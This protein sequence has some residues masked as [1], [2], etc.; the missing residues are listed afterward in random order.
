MNDQ[1]PAPTTR[2]DV[3]PDTG[4]HPGSL[5]N[6][7]FVLLCVSSFIGSIG[8][9]FGLLAIPW[10]ALQLSGSPL[11]LGALLGLEGM[12]RAALMLVGG[13][14]CD[15]YAPRPILL[16]GACIN[17]C[18][19]ILMATLIWTGTVQ[20]WI[21]FPIALVTGALSGF[22][23]P[24]SGSIV[25]AMV[26]QNHLQSANAIIMGSQQ[27]IGIFGPVIAGMV[28]G[29]FDKALP[30]IS[31]VFAISALTFIVSAASLTAIGR[32]KIQWLQTT[33]TGDWLTSL[34]N[35]IV[36]GVAYVTGNPELRFFTIGAG[37]ANL[38][39]IGPIIVGIP[40]LAAQ[41]F[42]GGAQTFGLLL[43][44]LSA[45]GL[46]GF[47]LAASL[48]KPGNTGIRVAMVSLMT[49][50]AIM[51]TGLA[52][53]QNVWLD[54]A[55]LLFSGIGNGYLTVLIL[56]RVQLATAA[57]MQGRVMSIFMLAGAGAAPL[58]QVISGAIA[59]QDVTLLFCGAGALCLLL[60]AWIANHA[61]LKTSARPS[62]ADRAANAG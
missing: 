61:A 25:P 35:S 58:S 5:W 1:G 36:S 15:A 14:I 30:G 49:A 8:A 21:L 38:L 42:S 57:D 37:L 27:I 46:T 6:R 17:I 4:L 59:Q 60:S 11:A 23:I 12:T 9:Q 52:F 47:A 43:A 31:V 50:M 53:S 2:E 28:I 39:V 33:T 26:T 29:F 44:S 41:R 10:L 16:A 18:L 3:R 51:M 7:D 22:T 40:V 19:S 62:A 13:A 45:G 24:A 32:G 20:L 48:P 56:T 34:K 54:A 55:L